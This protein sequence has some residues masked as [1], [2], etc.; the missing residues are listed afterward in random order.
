[1][2]LDLVQ[3]VIGDIL[4]AK[5]QNRLLKVIL[6]LFEQRHFGRC[7]QIEPRNGKGTPSVKS[8]VRGQ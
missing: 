6:H 4:F 1:M 5:L 2:G 8:G 7:D 3:F